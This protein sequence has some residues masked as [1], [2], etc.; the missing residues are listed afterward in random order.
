MNGSELVPDPIEI[1]MSEVKFITGL[2]IAEPLTVLLCTCP[3][4]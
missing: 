1:G 3:L 2:T 4:T